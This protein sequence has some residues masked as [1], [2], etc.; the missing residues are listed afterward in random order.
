MK[1]IISVL[2][3]T[4]GISLCMAQNVR[5]AAEEQKRREAQQRQAAD[6]FKRRGE[7][8]IAPP[9]PQPAATP[10]NV[11]QSS[12][13]KSVAQP[14]VEEEYVDQPFS[15]QNT[16]AGIILRGGT[17]SYKL[18]WLQRSV[19][20]HNTY[21]VEV[22]NNESIPPRTLEYKGAIN[23]TIILRGVGGNRIVRLSSNGAMFTV[24]A[25]VTFVLDNN[26]TLMGH[27]DNTGV[28]VR[29]NGGALRMN[30]G[31]TITGNGALG[32]H[33]DSGTFEMTGG[34]IS[35]NRGNN[36]GG[37]HVGTGHTFTMTGGTITGNTANNGGGVFVSTGQGRDATFTMRGGTITGNSATT[38][39]GGV[40]VHTLGN[41]VGIFTKT[42]GTITGYNSDQVNG[43]AVRDADG[44]IARSGHAVW[45]HP[46]WNDQGRRKETTAGQNVNLNSG[47][48][49]NWDQ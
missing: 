28:M 19:E 49:D 34:T 33:V 14:V 15:T 45:V 16:S 20:S 42:G 24:N 3:F 36:G 9:T 8:N 30:N 39:G 46:R 4:F 29:V 13:P 40:Y 41:G 44:T 35:G 27:N 17:L 6:E 47:T 2:A 23:A 48:A 38:N 32:V 18:D 10:V 7:I 5:D 26:I 31:A 11:V 43:N 22:N 37:V 25:N 12:P 1:I 21:I